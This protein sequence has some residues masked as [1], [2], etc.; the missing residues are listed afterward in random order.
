MTHIA[1]TVFQRSGAERG[2]RAFPV[3]LTRLTP[4]P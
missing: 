2:V 1:L 3:G 4:G